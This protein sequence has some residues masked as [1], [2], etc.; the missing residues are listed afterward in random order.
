[1]L[2][3]WLPAGAE[4]VGQDVIILAAIVTAVGVLVRQGW[5]VVKFFRDM[6]EHI[7]DVPKLRADLQGLAEERRADTAEFRAEIARLREENS[8]Q[9]AEARAE[10]GARFDAIEA[11]I[12]APSRKRSA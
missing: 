11:H 1:M 4:A 6:A 8:A 9:H 12:T 5:K 10:Y 7:A 3:G 2:S